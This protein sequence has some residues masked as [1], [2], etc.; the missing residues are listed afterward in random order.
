MYFNDKSFLIIILLTTFQDT[1][2]NVFDR[3]CTEFQRDIFTNN[4][5]Y[6]EIICIILTKIAFNIHLNNILQLQ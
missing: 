4:Y 1:L 5:I 3:K 2:H 6:Y